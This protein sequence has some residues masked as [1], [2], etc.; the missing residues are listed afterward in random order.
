LHHAFLTLAGV[1]V[2]SSLAFWTLRRDDGESISKGAKGV[3][4][5]DKGAPSPVRT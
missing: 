2:L 1:T 4:S 5:S 3:K